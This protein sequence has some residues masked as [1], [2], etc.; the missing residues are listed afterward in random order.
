M[1][2]M[3]EN[4]STRVKTC[5][6]AT[7]STKNSMQTDLG[8]N[9]GLCS[10]RQPNNCLNHGTAT[11]SD[12]CNAHIYSKEIPCYVYVYTYTY[13]YIYIFILYKNIQPVVYSSLVYTYVYRDTQPSQFVDLCVSAVT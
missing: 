8:S 12:S 9:V 10:V 3:G 6:I 1:I 11:S 13:I 7:L 5:S 2:L 4:I